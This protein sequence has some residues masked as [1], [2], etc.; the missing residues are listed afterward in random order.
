[1]VENHGKDVLLQI[2]KWL[3]KDITESF[4][5]RLFKEKGY[6]ETKYKREFNVDQRQKIDH[7]EP[8]ENYDI[9]LAYKILQRVCGLASPLDPTWFKIDGKCLSVESKIQFVKQLRNILAHEEQSFTDQE[10][11]SIVENLKH[12]LIDLLKDVGQRMKVSEDEISCKIYTI[13][14]E[15]QVVYNKI[16][17]PLDPTDIN[18][19]HELQEEARQFKIQLKS[20]LLDIAHNE[21]NELFAKLCK[22]E[23]APWAIHQKYEANPTQV[24]V[25]VKVKE[26]EDLSSI[27]GGYE[28]PEVPCDDILEVKNS[29]GILPDVIILSGEGG[30]GKTSLVKYFLEEYPKG[31]HCAVTRLSSNELVFHVEGRNDQLSNLQDLLRSCIPHTYSHMS[32]SHDHLKDILMDVKK[33]ILIDGFDEQNSNSRK[34]VKELLNLPGNNRYIITTRPNSVEDINMLIPSVKSKVNLLLQGIP[35]HQHENFVEKLLSALLSDQ[36][37]IVQ[38]TDNIVCCLNRLKQTLGDQLNTPLTLAL[39][40]LLYVMSPHTINNLTS[41]SD[42]YEELRIMMTE[43]LVYRLVTSTTLSETTAKKQ[44][45]KFLDFFDQMSFRT[46]CMNEFELRRSTTENLSDKCELLNLPEDLVLSS[47][48]NTKRSLRGFSTVKIY[49]YQHTMMQE[50]AAGKYIANN[51]IKYLTE[52]EFSKDETKDRS[53]NRNENEY[54][55]ELSNMIKFYNDQ[56]EEVQ[57]SG[58]SS[59]RSCM[60]KSSEGSPAASQWKVD[61]QNIIWSVL[62][63]EFPVIG[64][65][66]TEEKINFVRKTQNV[67]M[68]M[69]GHVRSER[70]E[71]LKTLADDIVRLIDDEKTTTGQPYIDMFTRLVAESHNNVHITQLVATEIERLTLNKYCIVRENSLSVFQQLLK[72]TSPKMI[73]VDINVAPNSVSDLLPTLQIITRQDAQL[74]LVFRH[75]YHDGHTGAC[76]DYLKM[77]SDESTCKLSE[78]WGR[79]TDEGMVWLPRS[80]GVLCLRLL[81]KQIPQLN[82]CI[83]HLNLWSLGNHSMFTLL[84]FIC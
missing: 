35:D 2:I 80:L 67:L 63:K 40:V 12:V 62:Q 8:L 26:D 73:A 27:R 24:F 6:S 49:T 45:K 51:L 4:K 59:E 68:F 75:M 47:Y 56:D 29:N 9:T 39:I 81:P 23:A 37:E 18:H 21:M 64:N 53:R 66:N 61:G 69:I 84:S 41:S 11:R 10:T 22:I 36:K 16:R 15:I 19:F 7:N 31:D 3:T 65:Y 34:L 43:K 28:T 74:S 52:K 14:K 38:A 32:L 5:E 83:A 33:L 46:F 60:R 1:M 42:L 55:D 71:F 44:C 30:K 76:D 58:L 82:E 50:F 25:R 78:F 48:L 57:F 70:S 79:L 13:E 17:E 77:F 54:N 72:Y 20:E